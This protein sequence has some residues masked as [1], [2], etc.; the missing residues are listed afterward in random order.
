M[1]FV[2]RAQSLIA[3]WKF[4]YYMNE[5]LEEENE[6][7]QRRFT[8]FPHMRDVFKNMTYYFENAEPLLNIPQPYSEKIKFIGGIGIKRVQSLNDEYQKLLN[9]SRR[10]TIL[11]SFGSLLRIEQVPLDVQ[12]EILKAFRLFE[13]YQFLWKHDKPEMLSKWLTNTSNVHLVSW[14]PQNDLLNDKRVTLFVTHSGMNSYMESMRASVPLIA[15]PLFADQPWNAAAIVEK[16]VGVQ[17]QPKQ[18]NSKT[19]SHAI[20]EVLNNE[21]YRERALEMSR[22]L[23]RKQ[24]TPRDHFVQLIEFAAD[25]PTLGQDLQLAGHDM[26][27]VTYFCVDV[28]L[29]F[30][31][32]S[33]AAFCFKSDSSHKKA[34]KP[35]K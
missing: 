20:Q 22:R 21:K 24:P 35:I 14:L 19:L 27:V 10:G 4:N 7:F 17:I 9:K 5:L 3:H 15:I 31:L 6:L 12:L 16:G 34:K 11:F 30:I 1:S 33:L 2:E 26:D 18:L 28:I 29:C 8:D 32:V 25:H 23:K 13:D